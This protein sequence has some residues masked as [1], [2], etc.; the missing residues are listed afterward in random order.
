MHKELSVDTIKPEALKCKLLNVSYN[1]LEEK[2]GPYGII[3]N[4]IC[5]SVNIKDDIVTFVFQRNVN[6]DKN[7]LF[8]IVVKVETSVKFKREDNYSDKDY[9]EFFK[10]NYMYYYRSTG[11]ASSISLIVGQIT[12]SFGRQPLLV[13]FKDK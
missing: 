6:T 12:S 3:V 2:N 1:A 11:V 13:A 4:D 8:E 10:N 5:N 7:L 9:Q